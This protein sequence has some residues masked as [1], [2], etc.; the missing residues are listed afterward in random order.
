MALPDSTGH[1]P[2][3]AAVRDALRRWEFEFRC[4]ALTALAGWDAAGVAPARWSEGAPELFFALAAVQRPSW[5]H[6]NGLLTALRKAR[7]LL[8]NTPG[9]DRD[10]LLVRGAE[11]G[12][13]LDRQDAHLPPGLGGFCLSARPGLP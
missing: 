8:L 4:D 10:A 1:L 13:I 5:G 6:W 3:E 7:N 9:P 2:P 12:R 11:L